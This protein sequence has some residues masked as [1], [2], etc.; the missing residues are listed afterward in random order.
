MTVSEIELRRHHRRARNA[1]V[2]DWAALG[3]EQ[4]AEDALAGFSGISLF[5]AQ[6]VQAAQRQ[7]MA[8]RRRR[9]TD[10]GISEDRICAWWAAYTT[11]FTGRLAELRARSI[12]RAPAQPAGP[13]LLRTLQEDRGEA[14]LN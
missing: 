14:D 11:T 2:A 10:A 1:P 3:A 5:D 4:G 7:R 6:T 9:L 12:P 8:D 13:A